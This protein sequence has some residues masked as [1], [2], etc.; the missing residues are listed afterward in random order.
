M[1]LIED[2]DEARELVKEEGEEFLKKLVSNLTLD[3]I[4]NEVK[5]IDK[6][7]AK[8]IKLWFEVNCIGKSR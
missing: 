4:V 7:L 6:R 3:D 1:K 5:R 2:F 8:L